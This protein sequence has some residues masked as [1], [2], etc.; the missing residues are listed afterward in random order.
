MYCS[1]PVTPGIFR[2]L[3]ESARRFSSVGNG[4][5][6]Q[7]ETFNEDSH[8]SATTLTSR[9]PVISASGAVVGTKMLG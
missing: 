5:D 7:G 1:Q 3:Q 9:F 4:G 6:S 2:S 8:Y